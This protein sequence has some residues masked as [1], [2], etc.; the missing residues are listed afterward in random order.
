MLRFRDQQ[1]P[2]DLHKSFMW[3]VHSDVKQNESSVE[4]F[5]M[6]GQPQCAC[7]TP[8]ANCIVLQHHRNGSALTVSQYD[9]SHLCKRHRG[10][11]SKT[12]MC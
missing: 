10:G 3:E 2:F 1:C 12:T 11:R 9:G 6:I 7:F 4:N 5:R 8:K